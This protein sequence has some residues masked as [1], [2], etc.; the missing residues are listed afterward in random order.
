MSRKGT[1]EVR[2]AGVVTAACALAPLLLGACAKED[3]RCLWEHDDL[4]RRVG[5]RVAGP[6]LDCGSEL[7]GAP[8]DDGQGS[9]ACLLDA[10]SDPGAWFLRINSI[11]SYL[12]TTFYSTPGAQLVIIDEYASSL[13]GEPPRYVRVRRCGTSALAFEAGSLDCFPAEAAYY[14]ADPPSAFPE[15]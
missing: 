15:G 1:S 14:C 7:L 13:E 10:P 12:Y 9:L 6:R 5:A 8:G 11:D 4:L 3:E 2:I